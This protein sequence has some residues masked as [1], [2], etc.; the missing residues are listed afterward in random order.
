MSASVERDTETPLQFVA[1]VDRRHDP[2]VVHSITSGS[3]I[4]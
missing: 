3:S 1:Q 4:V 2:R